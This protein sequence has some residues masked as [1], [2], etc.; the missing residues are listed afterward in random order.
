ML[1]PVPDTDTCVEGIDT[2][3]AHIKSPKRLRSLSPARRRVTRSMSTKKKT[4]RDSQLIYLFFINKF[5]FTVSYLF[6]QH[7]LLA[8][9]CLICK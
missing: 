5:Y 9:T 8:Y 2:G 4:K 7:T 3:A 1:N 6:L